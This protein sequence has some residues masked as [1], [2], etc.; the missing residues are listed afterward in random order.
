MNNNL[1]LVIIYLYYRSCFL[2]LVT[3]KFRATLGKSKLVRKGERVLI[4]V[5]GSQCSMTL[6]DLIWAGLQ[7][8]T[9]K[10]LTFDPIILH[11]DGKIIIWLMTKIRS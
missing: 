5:S 1:L 7:Q 3:H 4:C 11:I 9:F 10:R 8:T 2:P 6:L